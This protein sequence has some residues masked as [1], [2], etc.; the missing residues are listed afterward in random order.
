VC[1]IG[2]IVNLRGQPVSAL[3]RRLAHMNDLLRHRGPDGDGM[4]MHERGHAGFAHRRLA[5]I[6][7]ETG[8]QPMTDE[9]GN[10]ITYNGEVYN[11]IELRD[12]LGLGEFR[13]TSDVEVVLRAY[14]RWGAKALDRLRGMFAFALWDEPEQR[15]FCARD[16]FGVKPLY[17]AVVD[18][19]FVC[20]SEAKA[21]LPFLPDIETDLDGLRDYLAFQLCLAG[22]TMFKGVH[23][24]PPGHLLTVQNGVVRVERYWEV[25]YEPDFDHTEHYF[26]DRL[27]EIIDDSVAM[28][29]RADVPVGAYLSGGLDSSIVASLA[30]REVGPSFKAFNGRFAAGPDY[31]ESAYARELAGW[32]EFELHEVEIGAQDF[33]DS[34]R[35]IA[36]HM[37]FPVAGP[38]AF[39]QYIVSRL[40]REHMKVVLGGQGG[41]ETFGGYARYL[42]AY[43]EQCIKAAIDGTM[44]NGNF[45]VTYESIIPNLET[46]RE[47]K[48]LMQEFWREGLFADLDQRYFRLIDRAPAL[49]EV[50]DWSILGDYSPFETFRSI[51][52]AGNVQKASYF[53]LMTHFD[54]KTLLPAL[55]HVEDRVSMAHGLESRV[56]FVDHEVVEFAA[57]LPADV[58]FRSGELKHALKQTATELLPT[59]ILE[60]KDKKGF[61]V[62]LGD[63]MHGELHDFLHDLLT[64]DTARQRPYLDPLFDVELLISREG[65]FSRNLWA[66]LSLELW[67]QEFHDRASEWRFQEDAA[68]VVAT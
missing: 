47:Y 11:Y 43:F 64:T 52:R 12:E 35:D 30:A 25:E 8:S 63:W 50:I 68:A 61:P 4:W 21:L 55:L 23:E 48:P 19:T 15:L 9:R 53:D 13:T 59:R 57:T 27:R 26:V 62:P 34:I 22:K 41:D 60:R 18:G 42:L 5:I 51:F 20:A 37:D 7:L 10:W 45:I 31:D 38:G 24:L 49:G 46:L 56:P 40:A 28:H 6:D 54:F 3:D 66:L 17:Y 33:V 32:R 39:P 65:R 58:K 36:Y 14:G 16:R 2:A 1:G 44:H 29:L 67:Q